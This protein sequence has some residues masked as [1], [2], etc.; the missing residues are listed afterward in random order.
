MRGVSAAPVL[1]VCCSN[2][3]AYLDRYAE[4]DK[5]WTDRD[6]RPLADPLLGR[7]HRHGRPPRPARGRRR[8][9]RGPVL[10]R[11]RARPRRGPACPRH[12]GHPPPGRRHRPGARGEAGHQSQP[13]ARGGARWTTWCTG[14]GSASRLQAPTARRRRWGVRPHPAPGEPPRMARRTA[15]HLAFW[16]HRGLLREDRRHRRRGGDAGG[17]PRVR[18]LGHLLAR[19]ARRARRPQARAAAHPLLD[20][21][22]G[23]APRP[24]AR[25]VLPRG[26]R[27]HGQVPPARRR[28]HLRRPG[29]HGAAVHDAPA[30]RRRARQL[31][32]PRRRPGREPAT[33]RR[34]SPRPHCS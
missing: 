25:E 28:R 29:P 30:A 26:R 27:G 22:A 33:P 24:R 23:P 16:R 9:P 20:E 1:I 14:A 2:P 21:R 34:A 7:R 6:L 3:Q 32:L 12:T 10:R 18:L 15:A 31:R 5:G 8:G 19:P 17:V 11:P 13:A 4:P